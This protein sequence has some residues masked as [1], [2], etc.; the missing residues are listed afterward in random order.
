MFTLTLNKIL[1]LSSPSAITEVKSSCQALSEF[2]GCLSLSFSTTRPFIWGVLFRQFHGSELGPWNCL[3]A[4]HRSTRVGWSPGKCQIS[5]VFSDLFTGSWQEQWEEDGAPDVHPSQGARA[6][7]AVQN[8]PRL[9]LAPWAGFSQG[10]LA[11]SATWNTAHHCF[12]QHHGLCFT[13]LLSEEFGRENREHLLESSPSARADPAYS[14]LPNLCL[15]PLCVVLSCVDPTCVQSFHS[16]PSVTSL[17]DTNTELVFPFTA[18]VFCNL[19]GE[20]ACCILGHV[21]VVY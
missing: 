6:A 3:V 1:V 7:V 21:H 19:V 9:V 15:F 18:S 13:L 20:G 2:L 17:W 5:S 8:G 16:Q 10:P 11:G 4:L 12:P 14:L